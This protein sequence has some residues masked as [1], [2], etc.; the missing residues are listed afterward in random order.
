MISCL[1][2]LQLHWCTCEDIYKGRQSQGSPGSRV[3]KSLGT[4][5]LGPSLLE[6]EAH[7]EGN[8]G[9]LGS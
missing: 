1:E 2:Q 7:R 3:E 6:A 4:S 9:S 8:A 5:L